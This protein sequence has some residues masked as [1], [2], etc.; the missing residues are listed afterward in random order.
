MSRAVIFVIVLMFLVPAGSII[1]STIDGNSIDRAV[2]SSG[3]DSEINTVVIQPDATTGKDTFIASDAA[4][5]HF[6]NQNFFAVGMNTGGEPRGLIQF[7]PDFSEGEIS[8]ATLSLYCTGIVNDPQG[9]NMSAHILTASWDQHGVLWNNRTNDTLW[10]APGGDYLTTIVSY[11]SVSQANS[12]FTLNITDVVRGWKNGSIPN[13]GLILTG[14]PL[15]SSA[16]A[17]YVML[18]SSEA[19]NPGIRPKLTITYGAEIEPTVPPQAT[20]EDTPISIDLSGRGH[21]TVEHVSA[22]ADAGDNIIPFR[23]EAGYNECRYQALYTSEEVGAEGKVVR[24]SVN[25]SLT[26]GD[27]SGNFSNVVIRM[28]HTDLD[29]LTDTF[30]DNYNG[31]LIE[32]FKANNLVMN[33]SDDNTWFSFDLNG[34][35]TY[36]SAHN[37]LID[38]QWKGDGG[39]SIGLQSHDSG[40]ALRRLWNQT[41][42]TSPTGDTDA[43]YPVHSVPV[44]KFSV[45]AVKNAAF[46]NSIYGVGYGYPFNPDSLSSLRMQTMWNRTEIGESSGTINKIYFQRTKAFS[47]PDEDWVVVE[48]FSIRLAHSNNESLGTVFEDNHMD[49]WV[50]VFNRSSYNVSVSGKPEWIGFVLDRPFVYNGNDN[51]V[52]DIRRTGGHGDTLYLSTNPVG[53]HGSFCVASS[54][55]SQSSSS[56]SNYT[57]VIRFEFANTPALTWSAVSSNTSLF[58]ASVSNNMLQITPAADAYG[59]GTVELT[60]HNGPYSTT[61]TIPVTVNPV[62][63]AP[64]ISPISAVTCTEDIPYELDV[65]PYLSDVDND[66]TELVIS[67]DSPYA[68]V[69]GTMVTLLY[70]EGVSRDSVNITAED[71]AGLSAMVEVQVTV[72]PVNDAPPFQNFADTL[73]CDATV[74]KVYTLSPVD[75]ETADG[76]FTVFTDSSYAT[77]NGDTITFLYPKGVGHQT[78]HIYLLDE[79]TY[80]TRN[81]VS[82]T[83]NVT[84]I[85]HPEVVNLSSA[86]NHITV[87]FDMDMDMASAESSFIMEKSGSS[88]SGVF[89]WDDARTFTFT[90]SV[91]L[92]GTYDMTIAGARATNG[93]AMLS[94]YVGNYTAPADLD[95]DGDG[96]PDS[97]EVANG[98]N[99]LNSSDAATDAD[100][101]G[102]S[103]FL[104]F[105]EGTQPNNNDTDGDGIVDGFDAAPLTPSE[106]TGGSSAASTAFDPMMI[107]VIV[108]LVVVVILAVMLAR[109]KP[110]APSGVP[111]VAPE[112]QGYVPPAQVEAP[113]PE[114]QAPQQPVS[115][116]APQEPVQSQVESAPAESPVEETGGSVSD[117]QPDGGTDTG[118]AEEADEPG[119]VL[120]LT[121]F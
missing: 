110:A 16:S 98:F 14:V 119:E 51:I 115:Y 107:L 33:S 40:S 117:S 93:A 43:G 80:G 89:V 45:D 92:N 101:D 27:F 116:E 77:V 59:S 65:A 3:S 47:S 72:S 9:I 61:Q 103:N 34:N 12:W 94:P 36:D 19:G 53:P 44:M 76:N 50:E 70:P 60:L 68:S 85:D 79:D 104:E 1:S 48:N 18:A 63:D 22:V 42:M 87:R 23:G 95:S 105:K 100:H 24:I 66:I 99:P 69:N 39:L 29:N 88:V 108:L 26:W 21:G 58:T 55:S 32:V 5:L 102:L 83:L 71:P 91:V 4:T 84:V 28:A 2:S 96:M 75:E 15:N 46:D 73:T 49:P 111:P 97:W 86:G 114:E 35:F 78:V 54:A 112:S 56:V 118:P 120:D 20:N 52:M 11:V 37:L 8:V 31:F 90:P 13:Y 10:G 113:V 38:I 74:S 81:N 57:P 109:K 64:A 67:A 17:S 25:R 30:D 121:E 62:N 41:D 7:S 106:D 82:Y 6:E